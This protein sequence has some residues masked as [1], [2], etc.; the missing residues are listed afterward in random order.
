[1]F[2]VVSTVLSADVA[3]GGTFTVGYPSGATDGNY[4]GGHKH[5][6]TANQAKFEAPNDFTL[7]F[8]D[9][10]IT[11]TYNGASTL[12][13]GQ[14]VRLQLDRPGDN[15]VLQTTNDAGKIVS[16]P[17][18][19]TKQSLIYIDLG[20]PLLADADGVS[21]SQS[22]AAGASFL[23]NGA[24]AGSGKV[25][26]DEPRNVVAA[27]TTTSILTITGK[28]VNGNTI[29]E[30]S[31]SGASH[32][33][34]KAFKQI[35]SVSSSA[36][37]TSATVGSGVVL[38]LPVFVGD[39][40]SILAEIREGTILG[41]LTDIVRV[42]FQIT[43]AEADAGGSFYVF[44]GFAG[45]VV[46]GGLTI[47][48]TVTTGGTISLEINNVAV[49]G[50]GLVVADG[51]TA[52]TVV[53]DNA[54]TNDGTEVFTAAQPLEIIVPSAF[55]ASAPV[56]GHINCQRT[57]TANGTLVAGL[58]IGTKS[59]AT[60]ADVRGTYSPIAAPDGTTQYGLLVLVDDLSFGGNDQYTG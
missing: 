47:E 50:F 6:M 8:G 4:A 19:V 36:S 27:W 60:T 46:G 51:A 1:M 49:A 17:V 25:V 54:L 23:I 21:A 20:S 42:P 56:N 18:N 35:D 2:D 32:T 48:N 9:T 39:S 22:V 14:T 58:A 11:V 43:E 15:K 40:R 28:D 24:L 37:I 29:V 41:R 5:L 12:A 30:K 33:G 44:P 52:G 7:S 26:F 57:T 55:N 31:A 53:S 3:T 10:S 59:T 13:A 38:G 45:S 16:L 34:V